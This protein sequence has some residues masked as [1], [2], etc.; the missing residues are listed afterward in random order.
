MNFGTEGLTTDIAIKLNEL[1]MLAE[2]IALCVKKN[3][4]GPPTPKT[5]V[6]EPGPFVALV[7]EK[8]VIV[9]ERARTR[10]TLR[11]R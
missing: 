8:Y 4:T 1:D 9:P 5:V 3:A 7:V 11:Q 10:L 2:D 6:Y